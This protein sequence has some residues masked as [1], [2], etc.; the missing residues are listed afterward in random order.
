MLANAFEVHEKLAQLNEKTFTGD[1]LR[2]KI[3]FLSDFGNGAAI[4]MILIDDGLKR[5]TCVSFGKV[6]NKSFDSIKI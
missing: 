6:A 1:R 2:L 3:V 5:K 4:M